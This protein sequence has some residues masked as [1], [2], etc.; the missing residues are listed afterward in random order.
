MN[1]TLSAMPAW[2][3]LVPL[4]C[5]LVVLGWLH[6]RRRPAAV[7]GGIDLAALAAAVSGFVLAGPLALLQP[8]V[9]T[10]AWATLNRLRTEAGLKPLS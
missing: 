3:A 5:Y 6:L 8:A 4:G 10:A 2:A 9:G 1:V 7:S